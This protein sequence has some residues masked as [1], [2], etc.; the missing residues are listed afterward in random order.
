MRE[1]TTYYYENETIQWKRADLNNG[2]HVVTLT[3]E[4]IM[5]FRNKGRDINLEMVRFPR[6]EFIVVVQHN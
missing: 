1:K 4:F 3:N 5:A 2:M 6:C